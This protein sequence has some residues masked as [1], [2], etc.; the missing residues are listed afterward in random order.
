MHPRNFAPPA[1]DEEVA[2]QKHQGEN[3]R[4]IFD[5][6][7]DETLAHEGLLDHKTRVAFVLDISNSMDSGTGS[8]PTRLILDGHMDKVVRRLACLARAFDD[9]GIMPIYS[10]G[11]T[12]NA[13]TFPLD[14][15]SE[16]NVQEFSI[17][18][19]IIESVED[20]TIRTATNYAPI[21]RKLIADFYPDRLKNLGKRRKNKGPGRFVFWVTDG[22]CQDHADSI[23]AFI[24]AASC[25]GFFVKFIGL[26][27]A[28][29]DFLQRLDDLPVKPQGSKLTDYCFFPCA[30]STNKNMRMI[31]NVDFKGCSIEYLNENGI[32]YPLVLEEYSQF[33]NESCNAGM[34]SDNTG[35]TGNAR[36]MKDYAEGGRIVHKRR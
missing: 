5:E 20:R 36:E 6:N 33:L 13:N 35:L 17:Q 19:N 1:Y 15:N 26:G 28:K 30:G 29:F 2:E 18:K 32:S 8:G 7:L 25:G 22:D 12:V 9:D 27:S 23:Q 4:N 21:M 10:F 14:V 34:I 11:K 16:K 24:D 3:D 31:D